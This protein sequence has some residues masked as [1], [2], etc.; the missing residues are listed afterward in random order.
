[1]VNLD[2][3]HT[4]SGWVKVPVN[5]LGIDPNQPYMVH[6]LLGDDKYIWHGE[7]NYIEVN[8]RISPAY[9]LKLRKRLKRETDFDYFI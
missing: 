3:F 6:D 4:Q 7:R 5:E 8:P 2:P 1:V 9:I